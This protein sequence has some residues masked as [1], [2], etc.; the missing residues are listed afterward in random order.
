V[1]NPSKTLTSSR[2]RCASYEVLRQ[3]TTRGKGRHSQSH[4]QSGQVREYAVYSRQA[5][6]QDGQV[7]DE[8]G[9][10]AIAQGTASAQP[11]NHL[12]AKADWG[13]H[14][15]ESVCV[16]GCVYSH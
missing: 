6:P 3:H 4:K 1:R 12:E 5:Q 2:K 9:A 14:F 16:L 10:E 13:Q 15:I 11:S 7:Q 8:W